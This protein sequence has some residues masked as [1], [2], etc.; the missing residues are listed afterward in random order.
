MLPDMVMP[1]GIRLHR[2]ALRFAASLLTTAIATPPAKAQAPAALAESV[3]P[4]PG[5]P[6]HAAVSQAAAPGETILAGRSG[7]VTVEAGHGRVVTL[8]G[9]AA[10]VYVADPKI[11]EVRPA[12]ANSLF[13]FGIGVGGTTLAALDTNGA[14]VT[15]LQINVLP[16]GTAS[17]AVNSALKRATPNVSA[18]LTPNPAGLALGG[19]AATPED[20][21]RAFTISRQYV[22]KDQTVQNNLGVRSGTQVSLQVTIA[23]MSRAVTRELGVSWQDLGGE[24]GRYGVLFANPINFLVSTGITGAALQSIKNTSLNNIIEALAQDNLA[25][26]LAQPNLTAMSGEPA[27]FLVGGEFPIPVADTNNTITVTFKQYGISLGFVPTVLDSGRINLHVRTEVSALT[28]AGAVALGSGNLS[29]Q[30]PALTVRRADT[31]VELGSG[32]SFAIA[33]LLQD[34]VTQQNNSVPYLGEVP[35]LGALFRST[36][37]LHNKSELVIMVTPV[38]VSPVDDRSRLHLPGDTYVPPNDAQRNLLTHEAERRDPLKQ[39]NQPIGGLN[40]FTL[41]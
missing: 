22:T 13:V 35:V 20:A 1:K 33:G 19:S 12:S 24:I 36:S 26:M 10:N 5:A 15:Q 18:H 8:A 6:A 40:G 16:S 38:I 23:E 39:V 31:T 34:T 41:Q 7:S 27:S 9:D 21:N 14:L 32:Q 29:I 25:H 37:F 30:I 28:N 17:N 4:A 11:A 2:L 3:A